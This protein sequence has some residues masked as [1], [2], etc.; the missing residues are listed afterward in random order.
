VT[1]R[2]QRYVQVHT[3]Q[4]PLNQF[5]AGTRGSPEPYDGV[6][7]L[8]WESA[9]DLAQASA[10]PEGQRAAAE[11]LQDERRF[12]DHGRSP[13]WIAEERPIVN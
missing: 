2:I 12:I 10:T 11:L 3:A 9:E 4:H 6:A 1:L 7:E 13:L 8:W 5:L